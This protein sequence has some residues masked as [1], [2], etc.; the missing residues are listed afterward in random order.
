MVSVSFSSFLFKKM[1][2]LP[3]GVLDLANAR[4]EALHDQD[5]CDSFPAFSPGVYLQF[6]NSPN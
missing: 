6:M 5:S 4:L 2:S 3:L 1:V